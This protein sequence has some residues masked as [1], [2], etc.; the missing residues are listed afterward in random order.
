M[1][2]GNPNKSHA[3]DSWFEELVKVAINEDVVVAYNQ[4][5]INMLLTSTA[6]NTVVKE[7]TNHEK[8]PTL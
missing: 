2:F 3:K 5:T 4:A 1:F 8:F 7:Q 6:I